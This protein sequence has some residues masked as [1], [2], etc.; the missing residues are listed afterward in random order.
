V[1]LSTFL[2]N[3]SYQICLTSTSTNYPTNGSNSSFLV[4]LRTIEYFAGFPFLNLDSISFSLIP[5]YSL[6]PS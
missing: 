4:P 6:T 5:S 1:T 2:T 3:P